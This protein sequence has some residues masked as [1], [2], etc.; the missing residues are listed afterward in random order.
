M[1]FVADLP[2]ISAVVATGDPEFE[3]PVKTNPAV[4]DPA[5]AA[6]LAL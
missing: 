4:A 5:A 2:V 3:N 6:R 1:V